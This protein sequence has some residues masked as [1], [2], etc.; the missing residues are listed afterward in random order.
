MEEVGSLL[1][2]EK[3]ERERDNETTFVNDNTGNIWEFPKF[4]Y[5]SESL[6]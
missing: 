2:L 4:C 3:R 5:S 6:V 1:H